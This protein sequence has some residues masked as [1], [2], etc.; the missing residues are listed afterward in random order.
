MPTIIAWS[1]QGDLIYFCWMERNRLNSIPEHWVLYL[2]RQSFRLKAF[3]SCIYTADIPENWILYILLQ[4]SKS[5]FILRVFLEIESCIYTAD[6][7][8]NWVSYLYRKSLL[9]KTCKSRI[10]IADVPENW[11][12][13]LYRKSFSILVLLTTK[14][15]QNWHFKW[16]HRC[17]CQSFHFQMFWWGHKQRSCQHIVLN[18]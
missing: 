11:V 14:G 10:Q 18:R 9:V 4:A 15:M 8:E 16:Q 17:P 5:L 7:H 2:Y 1:L 12:L 6:V 13:H 3:K